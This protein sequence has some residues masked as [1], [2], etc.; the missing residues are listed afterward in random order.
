MKRASIDIG[1]NSILLLAGDFTFEMNILA[2][3]SRVV[4]LGKDLDIN[5]EF[6]ADKI[7]L[8]F[9]VLKEYKKICD[10]LSISSIIVTATEATRVAKN[11][12]LLLDKMDKELGLNVKIISGEGEAFYTA[13]GV[14]SGL[15]N[16]SDTV[17]IM[18]IGGASTELIKVNLGPFSIES[19]I[20]L[21]V[22]SVRMKD[23]KKDGSDEMKVQDILKEYNVESFITDNLTCVAGT[24]TTVGAMLGKLDIFDEDT[25]DGSTYLGSELENIF[26]EIEDFS[27]DDILLKY[28]VTGKRSLT[29]VGGLK[30]ALIIGKA[31]SVKSY[32]ISTKGLY[33]GTLIEGKI[34]DRFICKS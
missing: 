34:D 3:E 27:K 18:D 25:I 28:P 9:D 11:S 17:V 31:L 20:S 1:S 24:M 2:K 6:R 23:W 4:G 7:D 21:P 19:S 12:H 15:N 33:Y 10:N 30:L 14:A 32:K 29:V 5:N 13:R 16:N 22:G 8:A 26:K